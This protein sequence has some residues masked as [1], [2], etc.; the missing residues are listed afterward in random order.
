MAWDPC[1]CHGTR[2][3]GRTAYAYPAILSDGQRVAEKIRLCPPG[4]EELRHLLRTRFY[5]QGKGFLLTS[6]EGS[7]CAACDA[8]IGT[9]PDALAFVTVY[10][11]K[12]SRQD[13]SARVHRRCVDDVGR[14]L[15]LMVPEPV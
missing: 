6:M 15:S 8:E 10:F 9:E 7:A 1:S 2:F 3:D 5:E 11:A 12:D 14:K 13:F 4:A